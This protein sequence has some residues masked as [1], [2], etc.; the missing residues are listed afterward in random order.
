VRWP[1]DFAEAHWL[2]DYRFGFVKRGL[3]GTLVSAL[4]EGF[5][6]RPTE[7]SIAV[8]SS[9]AFAVFAV[10][11]FALTLRVVHRLGWSPAAALAAVV[12]LSSPF[13]VMSAHLV[14]Y[15]DNILI[16]MAVVSVVL[17]LRERVWSAA[18]VQAVAVLIHESAILIGF[19][20]VCLAWLSIN[21]GRRASGKRGLSIVPMGIP[22]AAFLIIS[23]ASSLFRPPD[24]EASFA[25]RLA[26]FPFI[27]ENRANLV[28][29]WLTITFAE[30][31]ALEGHRLIERL[32][33]AAMYGLVLPSMLALLCLSFDAYRI[34][35][36]SMRSLVLL[37]VCLIPQS[38]HALAVDTP[39]I[40]TYSIASAFLALWAS[41][42]TSREKEHHS[43]G[44]K[45]LLLAALVTNVVSLTPLMDGETDRFGYATRML[46]YAP[47]IGA[48]LALLW[49]PSEGREG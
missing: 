45:I 48:M 33:S 26:E 14:G 10:A 22:L 35:I 20:V 47:V 39:R 41:A 30:Y 40:W 3:V 46:L 4:T 9:I 29:W 1:N 7:Q 17:L 6:A 38:L 11:I 44:M 37:G 12:F 27:Q 34:R 19:P 2:L 28:P 24:F 36:L 5:G 8:L 15:F 49:E 13:I 31:Y 18:I 25:R 21:D 16:L 42:E 43:Q 32:T 23:A